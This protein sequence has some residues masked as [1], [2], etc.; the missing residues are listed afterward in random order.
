MNR[1]DMM[2]RT[3]LLVE[4]GTLCFLDVGLALWKHN[5]PVNGWKEPDV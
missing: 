3:V 2:K 4:N 5:E 1:M